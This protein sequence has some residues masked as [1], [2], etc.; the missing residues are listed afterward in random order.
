MNTNAFAVAAAGA[1][2]KGGHKV[3]PPGAQAK[4][5]R[6]WRRSL[7]EAERREREAGR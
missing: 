5:D 2:A 1:L 3:V 4:M 6:E 7:R